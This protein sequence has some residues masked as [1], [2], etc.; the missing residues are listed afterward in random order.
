MKKWLNKFREFFS[1]KR[2]KNELSNSV[3]GKQMIFILLWRKELI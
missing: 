2:R 3:E 1:V